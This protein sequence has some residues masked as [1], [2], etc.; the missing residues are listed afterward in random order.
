MPCASQNTEAKTLPTDVYVFGRFGRLSPVAVHSTDSQFDSGRKWWIHVSSIVTYLCKNS[1]LLRWN[2][3]KQRFKSSTHCCFWSTVG[4][5]GTH[6]EHS[7]LFDKCSC[8]MRNTLPSDIFNSSTISR[9]FTRLKSA[10]HLLTIPTE[11]SPNNTYQA[12]ALLEQF[13]PIRKQC[14]INTRNSDLSI[15]LKICNSNLT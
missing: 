4:K 9:N 1:F 8:K 11:R 13:F 10:Y 6:F 14:F 5:R 2:S 7:F 12:I 15:V 3:C